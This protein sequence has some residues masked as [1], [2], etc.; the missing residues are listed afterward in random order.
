MMTL[1]QKFMIFFFFLA[2]YSVSTLSSYTA[3]WLPVIALFGF[4]A[5]FS[6]L[7]ILR[8]N[9]AKV[10][11]LVLLWYGVILICA[12]GCFRTSF[13]RDLIFYSISGIVLTGSV[14]VDERTSYDCL[15][16][17]LAASFL[18]LVGIGIQLF[19]PAFFDR[20]IFPLFRAASR[21]D[22]IRQYY[23]HKMYSG[24][25]SETSVCAQFLMLGLVCFYCTGGHKK[26]NWKAVIIVIILLIGIILTGKRSS[27]F[28]FAASFIYMLLVSV[29]RSKKGKRVLSILLGITVFLIIAVIAFPKIAAVSTSRNTI[30]RIVESFSE[31][32]DFSNGRFTIWGN[33][34]AAFL[35]H[36][37]TGNGWSW[38]L[39]N[40]GYGAHNTYLQLLC[41][42]GIFGGSFILCAIA[43]FFLLC[44]R[45]MKAALMSKSPYRIAVAKFCI[46]SQTYFLLYC[47]TGN[48]LYNYSF[49]LWYILSICL[50]NAGLSS[51]EETAISD[52]SVY[53]EIS[54]IK[55]TSEINAVIH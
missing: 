14:W 29:P 15:K 20:M 54:D 52:G 2:L 32:E 10:N 18:F 42:C 47:I 16:I 38:Y 46:F 33:A 4:S 49:F 7:T 24:F 19:S 34:W 36:P 37:V 21:D 45:N 22:V 3:S 41:E 8:K 50:I 12:I 44:H 23:Y 43:Y 55:D 53:S 9:Q 39:I 1:S 48:P 28:F 40:Y 6:L 27:L 51:R 25:S 17:M 31:D 13:F 30:V 5:L 35:E 26:S 11:V